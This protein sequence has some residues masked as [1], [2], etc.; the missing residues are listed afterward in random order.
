MEHD[1]AVNRDNVVAEGSRRDARDDRCSRRQIA[2]EHAEVVGDSL[3]QED[4]GKPGATVKVPELDLD[5]EAR[6]PSLLAEAALPGNQRVRE[7]AG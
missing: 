7:H 3:V 4:V 5:K 2:R 6:T 1:G